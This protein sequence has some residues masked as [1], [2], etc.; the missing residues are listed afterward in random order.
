MKFEVE[1]TK[2]R[3]KFLGRG[4][5]DVS[6]KVLFGKKMLNIGRRDRK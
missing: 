1:E 3:V 2:A 6:G 5:I 4:T